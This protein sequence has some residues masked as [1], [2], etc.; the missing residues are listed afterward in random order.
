[1]ELQQLR[2]FAKA[3][4]F[5]SFTK[6]AEA[7]LVSQPSLSQQIAKL[8]QELGQPLFERDGRVYRSLAGDLPKRTVALSAVHFR[9]KLFERFLGRVKG[10]GK[11]RESSCKQ[12]PRQ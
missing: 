8:E 11:N 4:H 6:A 7:C 10:A 12:N 1:M 2:Y 3:A 9:T 5:G